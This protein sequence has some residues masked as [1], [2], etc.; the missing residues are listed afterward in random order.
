MSA[1]AG[2]C[3]DALD[4][5]RDLVSELR[6]VEDATAHLDTIDT[7]TSPPSLAVPPTG[8]HTVLTF[9]VGRSRGFD[10]AVTVVDDGTVAD[11]TAP[12]LARLADEAD[13]WARAEVDH[14]VRTARPVLALVP[15]D[16]AA[17]RAAILADRQALALGVDTDLADLR[18]RLAPWRGQ[19]KTSYLLDFH[20]P[21]VDAHETHTTALVLCAHAVAA[22]E[23]ASRGAQ[24]SLRNTLEAGAGLV[25]VLLA[26]WRA[27]QVPPRQATRE[28]LTMAATGADVLAFVAMPRPDVAKAARLTAQGLRWLES[29]IPEP[30][31]VELP[32]GV[33]S[34]RGR[35]EGAGAEQTA[36]GLATAVAD[37]VA[38][39]VEV[40][41][42]IGAVTRGHEDLVARATLAPREPDRLRPGRFDH[43]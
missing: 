28:F 3:R 42:E 24:R 37:V 30:P 43:V 8:V 4:G 26:G 11:R 2:A 23:L 17:L 6:L 20:G 34:R 14:L 29:T 1:D 19:A 33:T 27:A 9:R 35:L 40:L 16:T 41:G 5:L 15:D 21:L 31:D 10:R 38:A 39:L 7:R 12:V 32:A 36:A 25:E 18:I 13:R 22:I